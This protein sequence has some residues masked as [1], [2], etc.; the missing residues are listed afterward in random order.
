[1]GLGPLA[2]LLSADG[3]I[4][5]ANR[6]AIA[7]F[8]RAKENGVGKPFWALPLGGSDPVQTERLRA[9]VAAAAR[10]EDIRFDLQYEEGSIRKVIDLWIRPLTST[11]GKPNHLVASAVDVTDRY[12]S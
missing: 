3:T 11:F 5:N 6:A 2:W 8:G 12:E 4:V 10:S 7:T 9:A 1:D